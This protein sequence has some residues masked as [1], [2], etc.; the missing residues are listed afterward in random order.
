VKNV[1]CMTGTDA[2]CEWE[3]DK[4]ASRRCLGA[5]WSTLKVGWKTRPYLCLMWPWPQHGL[6]SSQALYDHWLVC[7]NCTY[8]LLPT[9]RHGKN[10]KVRETNQE[11]GPGSAELGLVSNL[12]RSSSLNNSQ[13]HPNVQMAYHGL[14]RCCLCGYPTDT[15]GRHIRTHRHLASI[16]SK[17]TFNEVQHWWS[18]VGGLRILYMHDH[19]GSHWSSPNLPRR[20]QVWSS[21]IAQ[22]AG[23]HKRRVIG[24]RSSGAGAKA[25]FSAL[26]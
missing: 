4:Y 14:F 2:H 13:S 6:F 25:D 20:L 17:Q 3:G 26:T 16:Y 22:V 5:P 23:T 11:A 7:G 8:L 10:R 9:A 21:V 1:R 19:S 15:R 12:T 24:H 18:E